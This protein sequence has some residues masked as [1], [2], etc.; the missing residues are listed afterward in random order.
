MR[1]CLKGAGLN[2]DGSTCRV[3]STTSISLNRD[4][5]SWSTAEAFV[6][7]HQ[8]YDAETGSTLNSFCCRNTAANIE[9]PS[10]YWDTCT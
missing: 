2:F 5:S 3:C 10:F 7:L 4:Q 1:V 8:S 6:D 9:L